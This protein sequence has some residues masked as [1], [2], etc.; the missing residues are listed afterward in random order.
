MTQNKEEKIISLVEEY[1]DGSIS[2]DIALLLENK[3]E[4][5]IYEAEYESKEKNRTQ[6]NTY[7]MWNSC[8]SY[9]TCSDVRQF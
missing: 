3:G 1:F 5:H 9:C 7:D 6:V 4:S 8:V 2:D